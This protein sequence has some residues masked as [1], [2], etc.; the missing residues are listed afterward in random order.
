MVRA[1]RG[2]CGR[3]RSRLLALFCLAVSASALAQGG[4][5][6]LTDDPG[7]PG[8]GHWEINLGAIAAHPPGR[9][10]IAAPDA[11]IN[12]GWGDHVQLK[13]DVPWVSSRED[14]RWKSGVGVANAG[15]KWRFVDKEQAGVSISTYPQFSRAVLGSSTRRGISDA[16]HQ[17]LVPV[18][19]AAEVNGTEVAAEVGRNFGSGGANS[20]WIAGV[21]AAHA[22]GP[23]RECMA[24]IHTTQAPGARIATLNFGLHWQLSDSLSLL[25]AVGRD[26]GSRSADRRSALVYLGVQVTR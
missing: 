16:G 19:I 15:L 13:V 17:F 26:F 7:T 9:W 2:V 11:D 6:M 20:Q 4:P 3:W 25:S 23:D 21:V 1:R 18:E 22:C 14:G 5:P 8:D 12:Y 10:S 24:E